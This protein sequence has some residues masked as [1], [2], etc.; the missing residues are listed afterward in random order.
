MVKLTESA[1]LRF[2]A[3]SLKD[4]SL[5]DSA[6]MPTHLDLEDSSL[7]PIRFSKKSLG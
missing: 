6:G 1:D 5:L 3:K 4:L 7:E 2:L